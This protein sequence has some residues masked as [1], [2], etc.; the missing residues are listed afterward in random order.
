MSVRVCVCVC[1]C[2]S[3]CMRVRRSPN[4]VGL[5][6]GLPYI[7]PTNQNNKH[8]LLCTF[9][10]MRRRG[11]SSAPPPAPAVPARP[12]PGG[13]Q[14]GLM[15]NMAST[16]AGVAIGSTVGHAISGALFGG[17]VGPQ[18]Q[19]AVSQQQQT[20]C[21]LQLDLSFLVGTLK[22]TM[23]TTLSPMP[24]TATKRSIA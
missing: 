12:A 1:A 6:F 14:P 4:V 2:A 20:P 16:A 18:A 3:V 15:A 8:Y 13:N 17:S 11:G 23:A 7:M 19:D 10:K 9:C 5:L 22:T 24:C 21:K